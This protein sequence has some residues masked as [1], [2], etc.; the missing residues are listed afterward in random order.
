MKRHGLQG[1]IDDA[2]M[3]SFL[4]VLPTGEPLHRTI[5][6]WVQREAN[7]AVKHWRQQFRGH[8]RV[9]R[10]QAVTDQDIA[11][12][13][14][15]LWGDVSSNKIIAKV[16]GDLPLKWS[17]QSVSL[18]EKLFDARK[19][20]PLL[21]YP[22]PLNPNK[23]VVIN[24]GFTYREYAYLNNARQV[25]MLPDWAIVDVVTKPEPN[26][27]IS[28]FPGIPVQADFFDE[29]WKVKTSVD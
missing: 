13:N 1:P 12:H 29:Y 11:N 21:I 23:Y 17:S 10:D 15:I 5:G 24:S 18:S 25:P 14:L 9:K 7:H 20:V 26:D 16:I 4:M 8:A 2:L 19:H 27:S 28:R 6:D 3:S 22:N